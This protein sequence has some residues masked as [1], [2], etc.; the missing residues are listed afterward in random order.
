MEELE[1]GTTLENGYLEGHD[2][3]DDNGFAELPFHD[4][5]RFAPG[6]RAS[7][8]SAVFVLPP[9]DELLLQFESAEAA[10]LEEPAEPNAQA[11]TNAS[12]TLRGTAL[13]C[14]H[15]LMV[16]QGWWDVLHPTLLANFNAW[17]RF[18]DALRRGE[19]SPEIAEQAP[20]IAD[21]ERDAFSTVWNR[22]PKRFRNHVA[23]PH[24]DERGELAIWDAWKSCDTRKEYLDQ[25]RT[26]EFTDD[27]PLEEQAEFYLRTSLAERRHL[28]AFELFFTN[29]A[30][31]RPQLFEINNYLTF[32]PLAHLGVTGPVT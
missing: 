14:E 11:F 32:G 29:A 9:F 27:E 12:L 16:L 3:G 28:D 19:R 21:G 4:Q 8:F 15:T 31:L 22:L 30:V 26:R 25:W 6:L 20:H 10:Y 24:S 7:E 2:G 23:W 13:D 17:R 5:P 18:A 1:D